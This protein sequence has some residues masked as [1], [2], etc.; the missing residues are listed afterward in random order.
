MRL[1]TSHLIS[2]PL[3]ACLRHAIAVC[4]AHEKKQPIH[5]GAQ[6]SSIRLPVS[7]SVMCLTPCPEICL[8]VYA[9]AHMNC[10]SQQQH[11]LECLL[12]WIAKIK[13][14]LLQLRHIRRHDLDERLTDWLFEH[15]RSWAPR[16]ARVLLSSCSSAWLEEVGRG[17]VATISAKP[18]H[19]ESTKLHQRPGEGGVDLQ[20]FLMTWLA[21]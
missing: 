3:Q 17:R 1:V 8:S 9:A 6:W 12:S 15:F 18:G 7:V 13:C 2:S 10:S 14:M 5:S 20:L 4:D 16:L 19:E 11:V 21:L